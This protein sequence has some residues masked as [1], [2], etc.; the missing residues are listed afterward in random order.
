MS[1]SSKP[2]LKV[3]VQLAK[4]DGMADETEL[5]LIRQIGSSNN[6]SDE[7]V[8]SAI[9]QAEALDSIPSLSHLNVDDR[10]DLLYNL[11]LIMK[12]DGIIDRTEMKFCLEIA[13]RVGFKEEVLFD[14]IEHSP[15]EDPEGRHKQE[16]IDRAQ[17]YY[18]G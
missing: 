4:I 18:T 8:E 3:L 14:L 17:K 5:E 10:F 13:K 9:E 1:D 15:D 7:D 11:V 6:V 2:H 16:L 12:A